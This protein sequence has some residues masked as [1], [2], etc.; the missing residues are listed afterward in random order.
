MSTD[1][2]GYCDC[3]DPEAWREGAACSDHDKT[4]RSDTSQVIRLACRPNVA[5]AV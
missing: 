5:V 1:S 4:N 2:E 3:G